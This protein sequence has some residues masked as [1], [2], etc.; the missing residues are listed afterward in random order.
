MTDLSPLLTR[1]RAATGPDREL[2]AEIWS[3]LVTPHVWSYDDNCHIHAQM[4]NGLW[5][6][7]AYD[8]PDYDPSPREFWRYRIEGHS[9]E[10]ECGDL[11]LL[12]SSLDACVA[13]A[14]RALPGM[15]LDDG[16]RW[17]LFQKALSIALQMQLRHG[18]PFTEFLALALCIAV[19]EALEAR[20]V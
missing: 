2:D 14:E 15:T 19:V 4:R 18:K 6:K 13:L 12:T 1:L 3:A 10:I 11:P 8:H 16:A 17:H 7:P 9:Q 5:D 20:N